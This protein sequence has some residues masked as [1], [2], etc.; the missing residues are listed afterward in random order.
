MANID[1]IKLPDNSEYNIQVKVTGATNGNVAVMDANG[2]VKDSGTALTDL[3]GALKPT[4]T[5]TFTHTYDGT[6]TIEDGMNDLKAQFD[7][8]SGAKGANW[9][10]EYISAKVEPG[11]YDLAFIDNALNKGRNYLQSCIF[12]D[13]GGA[14]WCGVFDSSNS[15]YYRFVPSNGTYDHRGTSKPT[16]GTTA[17]LLI[18]EYTI[19]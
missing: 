8:Y 19:V 10:F 18:Q 13:T 4:G 12:I 1:K 2:N 14:M 17:T 5:H 16:S 3:T 9:R 11:T 7:T 15:L 6:E